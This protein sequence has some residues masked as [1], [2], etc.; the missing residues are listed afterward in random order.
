M[1]ISKQ[2]ENNNLLNAWARVM[3]EQTFVFN[4]A[5]G[6][7]AP[8]NDNCDVY[9]QPERED[10]A[11]ALDA[12]IKKMARVLRFWPKPK[13]FADTINLGSNYVW[14]QIWM[15][16]S[17]GKI[18]ELGQRATTLLAANSLVTYSKNPVNNIVD[19][20]A[21]IGPFATSV[22][23]PDEI[24][25][26]FRAADGA[27]GAGD[28]RYQIEPIS[29]S[30]SGGA[31]T[32]TADRAL[33]VMPNTIWDVPF[34]PTDPN[35]TERNFA[36]TGAAT[37]FVTMVDVYRVYNDTTTPVD[38]LDRNNTV[39]GSFDGSIWDARLGLVEMADSCC[40][41]VQTCGTAMK[42]QIHYRAGEPL[43]Y[44]QM[45][46]ELEEACVRLANTLMPNP[47]CSF[48]NRAQDRWN[49]DREAPVDKSGNAVLS[50]ADMRNEFGN[51]MRGTVW[52]WKVATDRALMRTSGKLT[53]RW[54]V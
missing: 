21:T 52:A 20:V 6:D 24:Q 39:L 36:D 14:G 43:T 53:R 19:N 46:S 48:R 17:S 28:P 54:R 22:T 51:F 37:D 33:F 13:W 50:E 8:L 5:Q 11:R 40:Q 18:I 44:G 1:A 35:L 38:I 2:V 34:L 49:Q 42:V 25:L 26:F 3:N 10:I 27:P 4:Q 30:I 7:G 15:P 29:V 16:P 32:I 45:D 23:D 41:L 47:I 9:I 31:A 12:A